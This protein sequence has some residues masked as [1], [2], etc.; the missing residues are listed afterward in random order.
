[1][2]FGLPTHVRIAKSWVMVYK[3]PQKLDDIWTERKTNKPPK[4]LSILGQKIEPGNET[5]KRANKNLKR[6]LNSEFD[7]ANRD[8]KKSWV[9]DYENLQKNR[10]KMESER[11]TD[12]PPKKLVAC[13]KIG[14]AGR[15]G[16]W[17]RVLG[18][19]YLYCSPKQTRFNMVVIKHKKLRF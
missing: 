12:N 19:L 5:K 11:K 6:L 1:M 3:N 9:M 15:R 13:V 7:D 4:K 10:I 14:P 18:Q 17:G 2:R 16:G 8:R